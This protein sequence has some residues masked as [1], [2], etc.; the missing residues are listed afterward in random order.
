MQTTVSG[1]L[2]ALAADFPGW[3]VWRSRDGRGRESDW[4]ATRRRMRRPVQPG[5]VR[6]LTAADTDGLRGLLEQQR[7]EELALAAA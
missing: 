6:R 4:N 5:I 3:H 2:A 1:T 7:A